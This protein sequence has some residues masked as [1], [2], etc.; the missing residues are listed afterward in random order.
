MRIDKGHICKNCCYYMN[1][2]GDTMTYCCIEPLYT[3]PRQQ[4]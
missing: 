2:D 3:E 4:Y 1:D